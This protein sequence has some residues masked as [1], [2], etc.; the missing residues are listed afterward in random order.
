[1]TSSAFSGAIG[2][3]GDFQGA[4]EDATYGRTTRVEKKLPPATPA[5]SIPARTGASGPISTPSSGT[6]G[7][8]ASPLTEFAYAERTFW[9]QRTTTTPDGLFT[10]AW[11][12]LKSIRFLDANSAEVVLNFKDAPT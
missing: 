9:A 7:G 5:P 6:G 1:M 3:G 8:V 11:S 12:P 4:F 2:E 10:L